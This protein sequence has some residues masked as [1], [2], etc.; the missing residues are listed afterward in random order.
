MVCKGICH[1]FKAKW[2]AHEYRY[3]NGQ[4]RCNTCEI[5]LEWD[6][7]WCPCCGLSLRTRPR[8]SKYKQVYAESKS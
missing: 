2:I 6:G 5:F 4:K 8:T 3:A 1:R 7:L